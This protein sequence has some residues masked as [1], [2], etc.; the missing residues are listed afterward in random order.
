MITY[1]TETTIDAPPAAVWKHLIDF[2]RHDE[3]SRHFK[4]RGEPAVGARG[5][6]E[7]EL[8]GRASGA[9]VVIRT[10][11]AGRELRWSGGPKGIVFGSHYFLMEALDGGSRTRFRHGES[12]S[13]VLA[14]LVWA[15]LKA[16]LGPS[17]EGFNQDLKLRVEQDA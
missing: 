11:D 7:F 9:P 14:P 6:V 16:Q 13:G 8:F 15:L 3:W 5:R 10:A 12:F 17:Y 2:A 1:E 4:L